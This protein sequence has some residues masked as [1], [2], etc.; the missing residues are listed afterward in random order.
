MGF[1]AT[2]AEPA[3]NAL[4]ITVE[5]LTNGAFKK[6]HLMYAV[7]V[8]VGCGSAGVT[9]GPVTVPLVLSMG[10]GF[11]NA[12]DAIEGFGI[13]SM[14]SIGPIIAVQTSGLW[15]KYKIQKQRK[16]HPSQSGETG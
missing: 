4:G 8:G 3:L 10:L 5:N 2:L 14:A 13:L 9:T 7:S 12:A 15:I 11:A 6:K 16:T 1:A